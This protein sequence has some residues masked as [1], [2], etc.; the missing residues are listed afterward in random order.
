MAINSY[1]APTS[2]R[3][4]SGFASSV[5]VFTTIMSMI[6]P[7][8]SE[9]SKSMLAPGVSMIVETSG[10]HVTTACTSSVWKAAIMSASEVLTTPS[11]SRSASPTE[12]SARASR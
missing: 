3:P 7:G 12:S 1:Q 5:S 10:F 6:S 2:A 11:R 8:M 4:K 9:L